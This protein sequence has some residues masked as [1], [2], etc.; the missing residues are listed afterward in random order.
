MKRA[1]FCAVLLTMV[2]WQR[3]GADGLDNWTSDTW[4][5]SKVSLGDIWGVAYGDGI[6]VE[7]GDRSVATSTTGTQW[8]P[9]AEL[10][11][12][13]NASVIF[14][15]IAV[16]ITGVFVLVGT[17]GT[18]F[19]SVDGINWVGQTSPNDN[20]LYA[21]TWGNGSFVAVGQST[22]I[23]TSSDGI[24]WKA[25]SVTPQGSDLLCVTY[26]NGLFVAAATNGLIYTS[27]DG[28]TWTQPGS[29]QETVNALAY[30]NGTFVGVG[31]SGSVA[32]SPDGSTWTQNTVTGAG[33]LYGV[34]FDNGLFVAD[35]ESGLVATSP[36][37]INWA[38][39]FDNFGLTGQLYE[40]ASYA[41][42]KIFLAGQNGT[43]VTLNWPND[44]NAV[45]SENGVSVAVGGQGL[46]VS[47][48]DS[49]T[50]TRQT[51]GTT[52]T[53]RAVVPGTVAHEFAF[54]AFGDQGTVAWSRN[55]VSWTQGGT[56]KT[57]GLYAAV[58]TADHTFVAV[59]AGGAVF[60]STDGMNWAAGNSGTNVTLRGLGYNTSYANP[61][62]LV[63]VGDDGTILTS[64]D[65]GLTW[66][67]QNSGVTDPLYACLYA[68]L[69]GVYVVGDSPALASPD[70]SHW[71][72][73]GSGSYPFHG[74]A[75]GDGT[76]VGVGELGAIQA[77]A[78]GSTWTGRTSPTT[79][80]LYGVTLANN[81]FLAV[82]QLG[83]IIGSAPYLAFG[84][85]NSGTSTNLTGLA[86]G[87]GLTTSNMV[88]VGEGGTILSSPDGTNF[89]PVASP[90]TNGLS[91]VTFA[92]GQFIAVGASG[93]I[94][95]SADGVTWDT[96]ASGTT[97]DL[98][99]VT[100]GKGQYVAV[101]ANATILIS[102]NG[103]TWSAVPVNKGKNIISVSFGNGQF[104]ALDSDGT[105]LISP[106]ASSSGNWMLNTPSVVSTLVS[107]TFANGIF[108]A[109]DAYGAV[110]S[111]SNGVNWSA[112]FAL[113]SNGDSSVA[114]FNGQL[115]AVGAGGSIISTPL[116]LGVSQ[117]DDNLYAVTYANGLYVAV[118]EKGAVLTSEDGKNWTASTYAGTANDLNGVAY[119]SGSYV[120]IG[121]NGWTVTS[122]DGVNWTSTSS[123]ATVNTLTGITFAD[124]RFAAVGR[125][126]TFMVSSDGIAWTS[127]STDATAT[128]T[129][130]DLAAVAYG[131]GQFVAAGRDSTTSFSSPDGGVWTQGGTGFSGN[132][133]TG[134]A[135]GNGIFVATDAVGAVFTSADGVNW[136][137]QA[138]TEQALNGVSFG[139]GLFVAVGS[140]GA[141]VSSLDGITW[142]AVPTAMPIR[143][144]S[145]LYGITYDGNAFCIVGA[146]GITF[147]SVPK[148][149]TVPVQ[150][151][152]SQTQYGSA[153]TDTN[154]S[155]Q[156]V[157]YGA[158]QF[159][160]LGR[161]S[162]TSFFSPSG[163]QWLQG[164]AGLSDNYYDG[165]VYGDG[166]YVA[167]DSN[168]GI[169][170]SPDG[171][172]WTRVA[173]LQTSLNGLAYGNGVF[174]AVGAQ[175]AVFTSSNAKQW[176][177]QTPAASDNLEAVIFD[178]NNFVSVGSAGDV[179]TSAKGVTWQSGGV[180]ANGL[181]YPLLAIAY[182]GVRYV[183]VGDSGLIF[184]SSDATPS[185]SWTQPTN[186][187]V[188][189]HSLAGVAWGAGQFIAVGS[190]GWMV[191]SPDGINWTAHNSTTVENLNAIQF[192]GAQFVVVGNNG[193]ILNVSQ[194]PVILAQP[195]PPSQFAAA[196]KS[197]TLQ[198]T[199]SGSQSLTY[200]W[201]L[202]SQNL[203]NSANVAGA[204]GPALTLTGVT[205]SSSGSYDVIVGDSLGSVT[206]AVAVVTVGIPPSITSQPLGTVGKETKLAGQDASFSVTATGTA[207]LRYSWLLNGTALSDGNG[208]LGSAT[209]ELLLNPIKTGLGG[210][211]TVVVSNPFGEETSSTA[212]LTV[213]SEPTKPSVTITSPTPNNVRTANLLLTGT[214]TDAI[215]VE[216]VRYWITNVNN[217]ETNMLFGMAALSGSASGV[218]ASNWVINI[219]PQAGSNTLAVESFNYSSSG[220][221]S[222]LA[223]RSFFYRVPSP[224]GLTVS[225][226]GRGSVIGA[227][228]IK[229]DP[230]PGAGANLYIGETY[231]ITAKP[232]AG[233]FFD[234]WTTN[235]GV[236]A[237]RQ[238]ALTFIM[239]KNY[240]FEADFSASIFPQM[241]GR[242]D[243][244][245]SIDNKPDIQTAGLISGLS[246]TDTGSYSGSIYLFGIKY[247]LSGAFNTAGQATNY[248]NRSTESG[249]RAQVIMNWSVLDSLAQ[250][251]GSVTSSLPRIPD[252]GFT[253][254]AKPFASQLYMPMAVQSGA[255]QDSQYTML[256][257]AP[258]DALLL[259]YGYATITN[260]VGTLTISGALADGQAF[261]QSVPL[262]QDNEFPLYAVPK[263][264]GVI[265]D[266][267]CG[268]L[269]L[270]TNA[271]SGVLGG[272]AAWYN[273][274]TLGQ[275]HQGIYPAGFDAT[276][277][278]QASPW[279]NSS[280]DLASLVPENS[281]LTL[282]GGDFPTLINAEVSLSAADQL[283]PKVSGGT[284]VGGS[285][286][287]QTGQFSISFK[288][289]K[290]VTITG[291]GVLLPNTDFG[292]GYFTISVSGGGVTHFVGGSIT[293]QPLASQVTVHEVDP[294]QR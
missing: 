14:K 33:S 228:S 15:S 91:A 82:G 86:V 130:D 290:N 38:T 227:S 125:S 221:R 172:A 167:M 155:L 270:S 268:R 6:Y 283:I 219:T 222:P 291:S 21:V 110:Y 285:I 137:Q 218:G 36:D 80:G 226:T 8:T 107:I 18:I 181:S 179:W 143:D 61:G 106:S 85:L 120:A 272:N 213:N 264:Q 153:A 69:A 192:A 13:A 16:S 67:A 256:I 70:A 157:V 293:L 45:A 170:T 262:G 89:V 176:I 199:G 217:G 250:L 142:T 243:G 47:S 73:Y 160:A 87:A 212:V 114:Y 204:T 59:G 261:S 150:V 275:Y 1:I 258:A 68:P 53:L 99:G 209:S 104:A 185:S 54:V 9:S 265:K 28:A 136:T 241:A 12:A 64:P 132:Y 149:L 205:L 124:A 234:Y 127:G 244:L 101:G 201:Q 108:L 25:A 287:T 105:M 188:T 119:G 49:I 34:T 267:I 255:A 3:C 232:A 216:E 242:Y 139:G 63:A 210:S 248:V 247:S 129:T 52:N 207:P 56:G 273:A 206:S 65:S 208:I 74:L 131:D 240:Q 162:G 178:G 245:F 55:G 134:I 161:D 46:I 260:H 20:H 135:Y 116:S 171:S 95:T 48:T 175:G 7:A 163:T 254:P 284:I 50:W 37:G 229:F 112:D 103:G 2:A 165:V 84:S 223:T 117:P 58:S 252:H 118:G 40:S 96:A 26:A 147:S 19:S 253:P 17:Y 249:G 224:F 238:P 203:A 233:W 151:Q 271:A 189:Y 184:T 24:N 288:D 168:G 39:D 92:D 146:Y 196:G 177:A 128:D 22:A 66:T 32:T 76:F 31:A 27:S 279:T 113:P 236:I 230:V 57:N 195:Q 281:I 251:N 140:Q 237:T 164:G 193:A 51:S 78:D 187:V 98:A 274:P 276:V 111:S 257:P 23:I 182:N 122:P 100:Y 277:A 191:T 43:N 71:T 180:E 169:F 166:L 197:V 280:V 152:L 60:T 97:N 259:G 278:V 194:A 158:G 183:A 154:D 186:Y 138:A 200:Q 29:A 286:N 115:Q 148:A 246:I 81:S 294:T 231:T 156:A 159:V 144:Q 266:F 198:V 269:S 214:A 215:R 145:D 72:Q 220:L 109:S 41:N 75:F 62:L 289:Y 173:G 79:S 202:N 126:Q 225:P 94:I 4:T 35:G 235:G 121:N 11:T 263:L 141:I 77:S 174:V 292:G 5:V 93:T 102:A 282:S 44:L 83:T 239:E 30:G 42:G 10:I 133:Y 211:Y 90:T 123:G 190:E 88:A